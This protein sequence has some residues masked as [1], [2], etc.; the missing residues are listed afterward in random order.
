MPCV[1]IIRPA[2]STHWPQI[3]ALLTHHALPLDGLSAHLDT[4]LV[5]L[6][7]ENGAGDDPD[8]GEVIGCAAVE[9]YGDAGLLRSVAVDA[10]QQ[11]RGLG[12]RLVD[13]ALELARAHGVTRLYLLTETAA[14]YFARRGFVP[15][16]RAEVAPAVAASVEFQHAC[17]ASAQ[18][19]HLALDSAHAR[20]PCAAPPSA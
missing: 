15:L 13:A 10:A 8:A 16:A 4:T 18:A 1:P 6:C 3:A 2:R 11:G 20:R 7:A 12:S 14:P 17:P 19:M 9:L 5:A